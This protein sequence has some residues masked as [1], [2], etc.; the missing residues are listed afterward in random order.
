MQRQGI[1]GARVSALGS[2]GAVGFEIQRQGDGRVSGI[3]EAV[4]VNAANILSSASL[5]I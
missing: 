5:I 3:V 1:V 4:S 2:E